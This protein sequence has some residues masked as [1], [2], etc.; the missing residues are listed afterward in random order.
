MTA[1]E[2]RALE[3]ELRQQTLALLDL[4]WALADECSV[5]DL[6]A[7]AGLCKATVYRLLQGQWKRPQLFTIQK[8]CRVVGLEVTLTED[9]SLSSRMPRR[10]LVA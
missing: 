3:L 1:K 4:I 7:D 2:K 10:F 9:G 6:A 8:L 5:A